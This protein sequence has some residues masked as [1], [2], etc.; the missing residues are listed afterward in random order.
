MIIHGYFLILIYKI[1]NYYNSHKHLKY[2]FKDYINIIR[3]IRLKLIDY[4]IINKCLFY[5]G[6]NSIHNYG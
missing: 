4:L 2:K 1:M 5:Q 6:S 3:K